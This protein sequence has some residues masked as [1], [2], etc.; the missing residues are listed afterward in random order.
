MMFKMLTIPHLF[1]KKKFLSKIVKIVN[2]KNMNK[3]RDPCYNNP[4]KINTKT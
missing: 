3:N 4:N 2:M 1:N